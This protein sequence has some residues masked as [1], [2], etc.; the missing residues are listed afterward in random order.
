MS[1]ILE[2][3]LLTTAGNNI[4][5]RSNN[6]LAKKH[7]DEPENYA[8]FI[9]NQI[10]NDK[11]Y[12]NYLKGNNLTILDIG[13]NIGLFSLHCVDCAKKIYSFEPTPKHFELLK[14][15]TKDFNVIIPV[16]IAISDCDADIPFYLSDSNT[17]M[18]SI[19]NRYGSEITVKSKSIYSF[20]KE[21][22]I[23][24]VD[25]VKCDIEGSEMIAL[26]EECVKPLFHIVD[27]WFIE[28]HSTQNTSTQENREIIK[29]NFEN[30]GYMCETIGHD[31]LYVFKL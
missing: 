27:K 18:N 24:K 17:T 12:L 26:K 15:F 20:L 10:N 7:F 22:N 2:R 23:E 30:V 29:K 14:E 4:Y 8:D 21:N 19:I 16:N 28:I 25:F 13:G 3:T 1:Y 31:S 11:I 6:I 9:I 5:I